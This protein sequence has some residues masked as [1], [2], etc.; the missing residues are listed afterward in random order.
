VVIALKPGQGKRWRCG[1]FPR[2]V[3]VVIGVK[4]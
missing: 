4:R 1:A 2:N 3:R